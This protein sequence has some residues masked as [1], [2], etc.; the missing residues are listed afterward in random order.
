MNTKI[1]LTAAVL[2]CAAT[3]G[4]FAAPPPGVIVDRSPDFQKV[5][6]G[7]PSIAILPNG[8]YVASHSWFGPGTNNDSSEVFGSADRGKTWRKLATLKGQWWSTI[9]VHRGALY[10]TGVSKQYGDIVIR[11]STDGG[12]TWTEPKDK[13]SG[14]LFEGKYHCAPVPVIVHG[15]RIWRAWEMAEGAR[16]Q[17]SALVLSAQEDA[18]LLE[19]ANWRMSEKLQHLWS[20]SQWIEGNMV[21][22]PGGKLVNVLRTSSGP[23]KAAIV[24]V[25]DDGTRLTHD[26]EKD[27]IPFPGGGSKFTIRFDPQTKRYWSL[28]NKQSDPPAG[29]NVLALTSSAD[30]RTWKADTFLLRHADDQ[31][32]AWQ[33]VDWLFDGD[34]IVAVSRTAWDGSHNYHD[35]NYLTFHR[36]ANFRAKTMAD[37]A[38]VMRQA[39]SCET[40]DLVITG[41]SWAIS[42]LT[43]KQKA[44]SNRNYV[45]QGLP[46]QFRNWRITQTAGGERA[47]IRVKAKR[48]TTLFAATATKQTGIDLAGWNAVAD[49]A[50]H[51]TDKNSTAMTIHSRPVKADEAVVV[52]QGNWSGMMV[53]LPPSPK[54]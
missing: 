15:G 53:L 11:R 14:L 5:Y 27:L 9:F 47:E 44:F 7:C 30:L 16:P 6:V 40:A 33:Y 45:W 28:G 34:D 29:R 20:N 18:D 38:P 43:D 17:W 3:R 8:D 49:S 13:H 54:P 51:Y 41:A 12:K 50:F 32:H 1:I 31:N 24:H 36:I 19:A 48:D 23:D 37:S 2:L 52:P 35:A 39:V 25:S 10:I 4:I 22:A 26:R 21:V 42:K 46:E